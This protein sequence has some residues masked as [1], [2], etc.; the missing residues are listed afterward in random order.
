MCSEIVKEKIET[1]L[2]SGSI[3]HALKENFITA[4]DLIIWISISAVSNETIIGFKALFKINIELAR[5]FLRNRPEYAELFSGLGGTRGSESLEILGIVGG[6]IE[7]KIE[8]KSIEKEIFDEKRG[9]KF[10]TKFPAYNI[11]CVNYE[12][13]TIENLVSDPKGWEYH[14]ASHDPYDPR[15]RW[16]ITLLE[17]CRE[18]KD[19][20]F[21]LLLKYDLLH[22]LPLWLVPIEKLIARCLYLTS[23]YGSQCGKI[24]KSYWLMVMRKHYLQIFKTLKTSGRL[25]DNI[26]TLFLG[27]ING[28]FPGFIDIK[29]VDFLHPFTYVLSQ[30]P[31][32]TQNYFLG[33]FL[34]KSKDEEVAQQALESFG[35][36]DHADEEIS[37]LITTYLNLKGKVFNTTDTL[38]EQVT[39][40]FPFDI[41]AMK[42]SQQESSW[43]IFTRPEWQHLLEKKTNPYNME[44]I[45]PER[46]EEISKLSKLMDRDFPGT[47]MIRQSCYQD[48]CEQSTALLRGTLTRAV[49][50]KF[51]WFKLPK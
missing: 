14:F 24:R 15:D 23:N 10:P 4:T 51:N 6:L 1:I 46:L 35:G 48:F 21:N 2:R 7:E 39:D 49:P 33:T 47:G 40:Y 36:T 31:V 32:T 28:F 20:P 3:F 41:Y 43:W 34:G 37:L 8:R 42:D 38:L 50:G 29:K 25:F 17:S 22:L 27:M 45:P 19:Y 5:E 11:V 18:E 12:C 9:A 30:H 16:L 26:S 44:P 13:E